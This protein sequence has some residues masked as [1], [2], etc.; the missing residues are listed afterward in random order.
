MPRRYRTAPEE[1]RP[2]TGARIETFGM[3]LRSVDVP[4]RPLTGARIETCAQARSTRRLIALGFIALIGDREHHHA[5]EAAR[6]ILRGLCV[7]E[8][9]N[10]RPVIRSFLDR[11]EIAVAVSLCY[12]WLYPDL[13]RAERRAIEA[14]LVRHILDPAAEAYADAK[15]DWL[16]RRENYTEL[17][18]R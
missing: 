9:W 13:S 17:I 5:L 11:A 8:S 3:M 2:L 12:D 10:P 6:T 14:A 18:K 15:T 4:G 7:A 1:S 16:G